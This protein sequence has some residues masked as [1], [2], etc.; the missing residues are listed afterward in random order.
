MPEEANI[1]TA[2]KPLPYH[3]SNLLNEDWGKFLDTLINLLKENGF[4]DKNSSKEL[5]LFVF[6]NVNSALSAIFGIIKSLKS[7]FK[8]LKPA[9]KLPIQYILHLLKN[10]NDIPAFFNSDADEWEMLQMETIYVTRPLKSQLE[11]M[12]TRKQLPACNIKNEGNGLFELKFAKEIKFQNERILAFR[13]LPIQ[14]T[15]KPCFYCGMQSHTPAECPGKF[16]NLEND[17]LELVGYLPFKQLN[18]IYKKTFTST[19]KI[20]NKLAAGIKTSQLRKDPYLMVYVAFMDLNRIYQ[21][22]FL[23]NIAFSIYNKWDA[24]FNSKKLVLDNKN[25]QLGLDCLRVKQYGRAEELLLKECHHKS[26]KRFFATIGMAFLALECGRTADMRNHLETASNFAVA[27]K[28]RLYAALLLARFYDLNHETWK[29][30]D[31]IKNITSLNSDCQETIYCKVQM[32]VKGSF[33]ESAFHILRSLMVDQRRLYMTMLMDPA[34][35]PIQAKVEDILLAQYQTLK[36][37]SETN[38]SRARHEI[39][40]LKLWFEKKDQTMQNNIQILENLEKSFARHSYFD[41][42]DVAAKSKA[43]NSACRTIREEKLNEIYDEANKSLTKWNGYHHFWTSYR[44]PSFFK[45]FSSI[46]LPIKKKIALATNLA[47]KNSSEPYRQAVQL[48]KEIN[49]SLKSLGPIYNR[50]VW[51]NLICSGMLIFGKKLFIVEIA[52]AV[53]AIIAT[54]ILGS[55]SPESPLNALAELSGN[56]WFQKKAGLFIALVVSPFVAL[57]LTM[58]RMTR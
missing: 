16:L 12:L 46:L 7:E 5:I 20:I 41:V 6:P 11:I 19:R 22:R 48:I 9:T 51:V 1:L 24:V 56:P 3:G 14:G 34:L 49:K 32:E 57:M 45:N 52:L 38:L 18:I 50:M 26:P 55:L 29:A 39:N 30:R 54:L 44:F 25:I 8:Q 10:K 42:L 13:K 17:G 21:P 37:S 15:L 28:E 23:W 2:I 27:E 33:K 43:L 4:A 31:I 40:E 47:K 36:H 58:R 53:V 35:I